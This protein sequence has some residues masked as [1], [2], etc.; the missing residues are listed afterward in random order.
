MEKPFQGSYNQIM[1]GSYMAVREIIKNPAC[2]ILRKKAGKIDKV[3]KDILMILEDMTETLQHAG[4]NG[5]AAPQVGV[6]Q[7]LVVVKKETTYIKLINPMIAESAGEQMS[8]EGC[9]SLP[10]VYA[11]VRRPESTIVRALDTGGKPFEMKAMHHLAAVFAH[12]I[13]HLDGI[14]MTDKAIRIVNYK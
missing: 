11:V 4:G 10:G 13:D 9:L 12:E 7:R 5:L 14:L 2:G 3:G 1:K 6:S 8:L